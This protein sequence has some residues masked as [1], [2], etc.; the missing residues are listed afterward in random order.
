MSDSLM[1]MS[2][3]WNIVWTVLCFL[4]AI[5]ILIAVHEYG[6]F[7]T[8]RLCGVKVLRFSL[9]FGKVLCSFK[10]RRGTD[11]SISLIPLGGYV[12]MLDSTEGEVKEEELE[13]EF[14]FQPVWKRFLIVFMGP[15]FNIVL[16]LA[17]YWLM[18]MIGVPGLRPA[19]T[20]VV[21]GSAAAAA[22]IENRDLFIS[23]GGDKVRTWQD[24]IFKLVEHIGESGV[25]VTVQKDL[26]AGAERTVSL[27]LSGWVLDRQNLKPLSSIGITPYVGEVTDKVAFVAQG[28]GAE[29]AGIRTGDRLLSLNGKPYKDWNSFTSEVRSMAPGSYADAGIERDG[30]KM[31]LKVLIRDRQDE[32]KTVG[33][34]GVAPAIDRNDSLLINAKYGPLESVGMSF[35]KT[36]EVLEF[37]WVTLG[38]LISGSIPVNNISGPIAVA[39]GAGETANMGIVYFLS[40]LGI[41]SVNLGIVNL[42]PLPVLDGGHLLFYAIEAVFRRPVPE[43]V[44]RYLMSFGVAVLVLLT[45]FTVFND[46]VYWN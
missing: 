22:G 41:I 29:L 38:K 28:S 34:F 31:D 19:V 37:T 6:H 24:T 7:I 14:N 45:V 21:P 42:I 2:S 44:Q 1:I 30:K 5:A 27:N 3:A 17:V 16:A 4:F 40:F 13:H 23:V 36:G 32:G 9:G 33:Y 35:Y 43:K 11:W 12:Q 20:D 46:I 10:D 8:A 18:F 25:P 15:F 26:G 39:R